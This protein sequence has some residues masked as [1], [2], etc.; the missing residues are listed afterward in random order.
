MHEAFAALY[1]RQPS[2]VVRA[3]GRVNLI[4]EHTDY[5]LLPVL[6]M[7]I[8]QAVTVAAAATGAPLVAAASRAF[9]DPVTVARGGEVHEAAGWARYL[10]GALREL[11]GLAPGRGAELFIES[12]LPPMGGLSSSSALTMALLAALNQCWALGLDR[13]ELVRRAIVAERHV[14]VESGGMDQEAIAFAEAGSALR[15]GFAP[16]SRVP[17]PLPDGVAFA[18]AYSGESAPKGG[19]ARDAYNERVLGAR[20]AAAMLCEMVGLEPSAPP[21]LADVAAVEVVDLLV[22]E[23]PPKMSAM[24]AAHAADLAVARLVT[25]TADSLDSRAKVPVRAIARH[26][27]GEAQRVDAAV[28]ALEATDAVSFGRL[29]D[30]SHNSLRNDFRCSTPALDRL[31]AAMRS[32]GAYGARL[33]GAGFGGFALAALPAERLPD[34]LEAAR[35]ATGGPAFEVRSAAGLALL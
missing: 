23:L 16:P 25:L 27:L 2:V 33:T 1:S 9:L 12:D 31:C 35:E 8:E 26:I 34:V 4:G 24:E 19:E 13:A 3:P 30:E 28:A 15:I 20:I 10:A 11:D 29:M 14:G 5:S 32:A 17:V 21:C 6:P 18:A 22:E 7:A